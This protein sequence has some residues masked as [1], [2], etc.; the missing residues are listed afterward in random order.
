[1]GMP[2]VP[3]A[4]GATMI[5]LL[6]SLVCLLVLAVISMTAINKALTGAGSTLPGTVASF[7]DKQYLMTIF[8]SMA[9][10][11]QDFDGRCVI[12]VTDD[13]S[14]WSEQLSLDDCFQG[15]SAW[16]REQ[17][18]G[19]ACMRDLDVDAYFYK[20]RTGYFSKAVLWNLPKSAYARY[21]RIRSVAVRRAIDSAALLAIVASVLFVYR[22]VE[23]TERCEFLARPAAKLFI[24]DVLVADE[25]PPIY[26]TRLAT[27][28]HTLR[29]VSPRNRTHEVEIEVVKGR[30]IRWVMNFVRGRL[31]EL[32]LNSEGKK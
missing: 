8:K 23:N 25:V 9:A 19:L 24:D 29:F 1:M 31:D 6:L 5:G 13:G 10:N 28:P 27:G 22:V 21:Q 32:P 12:I 2:V 7:E 3:V 15:I 14:K 11:A 18:Q 26:R 16:S 30:Q 20:R 4:R 17:L